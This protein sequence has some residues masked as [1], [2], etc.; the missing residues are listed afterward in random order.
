MDINIMIVLLLNIYQ[1]RI[2]KFT[3]HNKDLI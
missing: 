1:F 3:F 2:I